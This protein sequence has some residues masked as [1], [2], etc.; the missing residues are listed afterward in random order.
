MPET[1]PKNQDL[2]NRLG[3]IEMSPEEFREAG[4]RLVDRIAEFLAELP[5]KP[6]TPNPLPSEIREKIGTGS[7]PQHGVPAANLL[8]ETARL[9]F[10]NSL[11]NGHP[12]FWGYITSSAAPI[13]AL[14]DML[15][16]AAN[17]NVGAW[18]LSPVAS[19][20][21]AQTIRWIAE[22][23]GYSPDCGGLLVSG[24]NMANF[25]GFLAGRKAKAGWDLRAAG[26]MGASRPLRVYVS[27][28]THTWIQKAADLFGLGTD[29]ICWIPVD[30]DLRMDVESLR[31]QIQADVDEGLQPFMVVGTAGSVGTGAVDPLPRIAEI[32]RE[33]DLWFHVDGAYGAVAAALPEASADLKGLAEADSIALDPH[34]WLYSPLEAGCVLVRNPQHLID[35]FSFRPEYYNF[36]SVGDEEPLN[37]YE[38]GLQNSR[39]F[40]A[41]KVWLG[42][43]QVGR[44]GYLQMIRDDIALTKTLGELL[45][46]QP[47]IQLLS[48]NLSIVTFRYRP[49][50][51]LTG[52]DSAEAYMNDLNRELLNRIQAGGEAYV[53]NA[54]IQGKFALRACIVNFRTTLADIEMLPEYVV[55]LGRKLDA[56][57]RPEGGIR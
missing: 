25:S 41:L 42:L 26:M 2:K 47:E 36:D 45:D 19:E 34:K 16:S 51:L 33:N 52:I 57:M 21:E 29:A 8:D 28:E 7:L 14:G 15:A 6:V 38:F 13:G 56:E 54:L 37:Y 55:K 4:Y 23:I 30:D 50:G 35:A 39:G 10:E 46:A 53:S 22:M 20:I 49:N 5:Q 9:L 27:A 32:C 12:R 44:Q 24:G 48:Q 43:R 17:P 11:F 40:R 3:P 31:K 18:S 1:H